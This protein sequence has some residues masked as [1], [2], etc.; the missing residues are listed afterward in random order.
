MFS[1]ILDTKFWENIT[2][3]WSSF[4]KYRPAYA[5]FCRTFGGS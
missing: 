5:T 1:N 3:K 4:W 2:G